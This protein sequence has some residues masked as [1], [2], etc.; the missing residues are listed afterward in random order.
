M[1]KEEQVFLKHLSD[2]Q[3]AAWNRNIVTFSD[4]CGLNELNIFYSSRADFSSVKTVTS[5]GYDT[6]ER[7][8][9]AFIPDALSYEWKFPIL[10]VNIRPLNA[11]FADVLTHRDYLGSLM[12]LGVDRSRIGD[13][14]VMDNYSACVFCEEKLA[15]YLS[16]ELTR[17]KHT[18]VVCTVSDPEEISYTPKTEEIGGTVASVRL[19]SLIALAF[20]MSRSAVIPLIEGGRTFINGR[21][22]TS[23]GARLKEGDIISVRGQGRFCLGALEG[24][25]KK[26]RQ[27]VRLRRYVS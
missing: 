26:G 21:L 13:I 1:T 18:S 22:S 5:G 19:D 11:K 2:L 12:N 17:V 10:A 25:T 9:I 15:G 4:F 27:F 7:Q 6:A 8:M 24:T 3:E 20:H 16:T 14:A 23:N